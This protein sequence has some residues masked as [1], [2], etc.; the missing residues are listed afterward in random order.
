MASDI[1]AILISRDI[2]FIIHHPTITNTHNPEQNEDK[3][4]KIN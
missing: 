2:P 1:K 4:G 3:K